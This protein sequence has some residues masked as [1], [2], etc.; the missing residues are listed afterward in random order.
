LP[1]PPTGRQHLGLVRRH[2]LLGQLQFRLRGVLAVLARAEVHV[3]GRFQGGFQR[4][5]D[6]LLFAGQ[7]Q[8]DHPA[9]QV[10]LLLFD[11]HIDGPRAVRHPRR[12]HLDD[13]SGVAPRRQRRPLAGRQ[14][15]GALRA[16]VAQLDPLARQAQS[17]DLNGA[18]LRQLTQ[19]G[20]Q[21]GDVPP[22]RPPHLQG[23]G[24][25]AARGV[26]A[27]HQLR[28][29]I[30]HDD[31]RRGDLRRRVRSHLDGVRG[32]PQ[33]RP[34]QQARGLAGD[35]DIDDVAPRQLRMARR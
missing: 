7:V 27:I 3:F 35:E 1:R 33:L 16:P 19:R 2:V 18:G 15:D 6:G 26:L 31:L 17:L 20:P 11:D 34:P 32:Q 24:E 21:G 12:R 8:L 22:F 10:V 9:F 14:L 28:F 4:H 25:F 13:A 30:C 29:V 5:L 23:G